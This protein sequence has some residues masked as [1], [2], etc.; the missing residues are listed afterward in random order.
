M[1]DIDKVLY[2]A[3]VDGMVDGVVPLDGDGDGHK[4]AARH[5]RLRDDTRQDSSVQ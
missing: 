5:G 4:D 2:L 3:E 1:I